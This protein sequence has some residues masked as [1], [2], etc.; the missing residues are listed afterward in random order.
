MPLEIAAVVDVAVS[1]VRPLMENSIGSSDR[2]TAGE[3]ARTIELYAQTRT[4]LAGRRR[5]LTGPRQSPQD[6]RSAVP[7]YGAI[8]PRPRSP[9][10]GPQAPYAIAA[11]SLGAASRAIELR[12][13]SVRTSAWQAIAACYGTFPADR[14]PD[15]CRPRKPRRGTRRGGPSSSSGS[16]STKVCQE[17][18]EALFG[19]KRKRRS[20]LPR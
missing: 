20:S 6:R 18:T 9:G 8:S 15:A 10:S 1:N 2:C 19:S 11:T 13:E 16:C 5:V 12:I 17:L 4:A 3:Y 14:G 7:R